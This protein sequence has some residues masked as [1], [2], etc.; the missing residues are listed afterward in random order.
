MPEDAHVNRLR[1]RPKPHCEICGDTIGVYEP[2]VLVRD[3]EGIVS[4]LASKDL[5]PQGGT[6][7]HLECFRN[8]QAAERSQAG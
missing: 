1:V 8:R 6:L 5:R 7:Y 3:D 2:Y 4:S